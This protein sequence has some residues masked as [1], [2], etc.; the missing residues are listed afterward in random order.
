MFVVI[1]SYFMLS[2]NIFSDSKFA[3]NTW[4]KIICIKVFDKKLYSA[5]LYLLF[6]TSLRIKAH[7]FLLWIS[8]WVPERGHDLHM[9]TASGEVEEKAGLPVE[10]S[11]LSTP[12]CLF[13]HLRNQEVRLDM[14]SGPDSLACDLGHITS[15]L[16]ASTFNKL[17]PFCLK[18]LSRVSNRLT[19]TTELWE[20]QGLQRG[21]CSSDH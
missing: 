20:A 16:W 8:S 11:H 17:Y 14:E 18:W 6:L 7:S 10:T 5:H 13:S 12:W 9:A 3:S 21:T 15:S 2:T 1:I 19:C 4:S